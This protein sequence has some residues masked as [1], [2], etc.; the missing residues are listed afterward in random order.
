MPG[1]TLLV[2]TKVTKTKGFHCAPLCL[3]RPYAQGDVC[4]IKVFYEGIMVHML[5]VSI[6]VQYPA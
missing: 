5:I 4:D 6:Y 1:Y 2:K 3:T